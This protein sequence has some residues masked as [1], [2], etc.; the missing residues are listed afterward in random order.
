MSRGRKW[1][2]FLFFCINLLLSSYY[3]DVWLTPNATS[4]ALPVVTLYENKSI[5]I[6]KYKDYSLDRSEVKGHYYSDKA[7]LGTFLVYPFYYIYK[8]VGLP[9]LKD[10]AL[11]K[12]PIYSSLIW[13][14][15][16]SLLLILSKYLFRSFTIFSR[17]FTRCSRK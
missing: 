6:D 10:S 12:Y 2:Y 4:R 8:S 14:S 5:V 11:K 15:S 9:E 3:L 17:S 7:P 13:A 1:F 16:K